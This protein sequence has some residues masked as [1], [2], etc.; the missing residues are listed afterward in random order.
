MVPMVEE[1]PRRRGRKK[2]RVR[3]KKAP[4]KL[5][6]KRR[7]PTTLAITL[8]AIPEFR[9]RVIQLV[10]RKLRKRPTMRAERSPGRM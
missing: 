8:M 5:A 7:Q 10:V 1:R 2:G 6:K 4:P 9:Q 3:S